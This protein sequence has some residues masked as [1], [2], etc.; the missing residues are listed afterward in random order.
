MALILKAHK[1]FE[2]PYG[3]LNDNAYGVIDQCDGN[4]GK[5]T[6]QIVFDIYKD[7][8]A[9]IDGKVPLVSHSYSVP[10]EEFDEW[11]SVAA[12]SEDEN[13]Y[14]M[15]YLYLVQLETTVDEVKVFVWRDW[16]SD[17]E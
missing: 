12:I 6:Q 1:K 3:N 11:F 14:K 15:A 2:D 8:Q 16:E 10:S 17:E 9:R 5:K 4:K 13:Q 7:K